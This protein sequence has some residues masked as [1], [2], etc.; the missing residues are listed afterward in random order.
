[1]RSTPQELTN[2]TTL[3]SSFSR[4]PS[5]SRT[6]SVP[7]ASPPPSQQAP[8]DQTDMYFVTFGSCNPTIGSHWLTHTIKI[9]VSLPLADTV[10][11]RSHGRL[12]LVQLNKIVTTAHEQCAI[13]RDACW[14]HN[15]CQFERGVQG[16]S[17]RMLTV[18]P[19]PP[20]GAGRL[21]RVIRTPTV[22]E[23]TQAS[24]RRWT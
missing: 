6:Q 9:I 24:S 17:P 21:T 1:M 11:T 23:D 4:E 15:F 7:S 14:K 13:T 18:M 16:D 5:T 8:F 22:P 12:L 20:A 3:A 2:F 10:C 19:R